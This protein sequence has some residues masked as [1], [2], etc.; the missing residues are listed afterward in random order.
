[1]IVQLDPIPYS[2]LEDLHRHMPRVAARI[3]DC[4][5]WLEADPVDPRV[6]RRQFTNGMRAISPI[7]DGEEI[8]ALEA[9]LNDLA[10][11]GCF[12]EPSPDWPPLPWPLV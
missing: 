7:I 4:L 6:R 9:R 10:T 8:D 3:E 1:M 12:P 5:D 2:T 11:T